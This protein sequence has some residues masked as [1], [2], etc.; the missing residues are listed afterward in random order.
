MFDPD[1]MRNEV[2]P[3]RLAMIGSQSVVR[4]DARATAMFRDLARDGVLDG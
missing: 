2:A 3:G 4:L 1:A